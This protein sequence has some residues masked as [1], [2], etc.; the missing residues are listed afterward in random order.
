MT[1]SATLWDEGC[2]GWCETWLWCWNTMSLS[3]VSVGGGWTESLWLSNLQCCL[4]QAEAIRVIFAQSFQL[5]S[6]FWNE[7]DWC[8]CTQDPNNPHILRHIAKCICKRS[9]TATCSRT[10][11]MALCLVLWKTGLGLEYPCLEN[12]SGYTHFQRPHVILQ[13]PLAE[14]VHKSPGSLEGERLWA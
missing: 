12:E 6:H 3:D 1:H 7:Q 13:E 2:Q 9:R 14:R 11:L 10:E 4:D 5:Q 8:E